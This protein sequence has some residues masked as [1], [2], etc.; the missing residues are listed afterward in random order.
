MRITFQDRNSYLP[1]LRLCNDPEARARD[2]DPGGDGPHRRAHSAGLEGRGT[3]DGGH[4]SEIQ[5][6]DAIQDKP[7]HTFVLTLN[8]GNIDLELTRRL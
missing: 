7:P 8:S 1:A 6:S 3:D 2:S 4:F 5:P